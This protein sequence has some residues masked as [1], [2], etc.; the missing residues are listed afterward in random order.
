MSSMYSPKPAFT[1]KTLPDSLLLRNASV[2]FTLR[3]LSGV[4]VDGMPQSAVIRRADL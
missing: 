2:Y 3:D 1:D 4:E